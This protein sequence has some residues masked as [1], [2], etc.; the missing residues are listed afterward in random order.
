[1]KPNTN[2]TSITILNLGPTLLQLRP[3]DVLPHDVTSPSENQQHYNCRNELL[4]PSQ[5]SGAR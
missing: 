3:K 2:D 4:S 5:S 1:M